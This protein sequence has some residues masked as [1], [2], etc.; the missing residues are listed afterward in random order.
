ME[1]EIK[2]QG[3]TCHGCTSRA[4]DTLRYHLQLPN[5]QSLLR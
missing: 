5:Y 3:M 1:L 4:Q 2:A